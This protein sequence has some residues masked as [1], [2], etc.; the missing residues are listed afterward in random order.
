MVYHKPQL[1]LILP[2]EV[3]PFRKEKWW[4]QLVGCTSLWKNE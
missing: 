3:V 4:R 2:F 1:F